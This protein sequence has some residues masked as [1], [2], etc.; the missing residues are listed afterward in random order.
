MP[1]LPLSAYS[2]S[3]PNPLNATP[4]GL[5]AY[6]GDLN[7]NRILKAYMSGIFPWYNEDD[8][9]LWWS[10]NPRC[11]L[12][13]DDFKCSKSL[14]KRIASKQY[15]VKFNENFTQTMRECALKKRE[16]QEGTWI[17]HEMIEAY[18]QLHEMGF[19]HSFESYENGELVG[20]G[21]GLSIGNIF[22]GESMFSHKS[23][24]SKV[25]LYH[26][27][28]HLKNR[29]FALIDCQI[30]TPHLLSLGATEIKREAFLQIVKT[31]LETPK[32]F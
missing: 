19:A 5:V 30:P 24:A 9:I 2:L 20:G 6:G 14:Q 21:Y 28:Q 26:L 27:V 17:H 13:P 11:I 22:C 1:I 3:F 15:E 10:P 4:E 23:D 18:T 12:K 31:A 29:G 7:P 8:P 32:E 25:A 16:G